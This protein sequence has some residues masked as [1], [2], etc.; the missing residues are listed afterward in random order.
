MEIPSGM[1]V[2][3]GKFLV[4]KKTIYRLLQSA[5]QFYIK[6][7]CQSTEKL[8]IQSQFGGSLSMGQEIQYINSYGG[9]LCLQLPNYWTWWGHQGSHW[10]F[11]KYDFGIKIEENLKDSWAA[12]S[13]LIRKMGLHGFNSHT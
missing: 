8:K 1:E 5:S 12:T 11:E 4:L 10:R 2:G 9:D 13:R 7:V 3:N 6:T